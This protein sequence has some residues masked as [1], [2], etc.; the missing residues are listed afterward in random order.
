M[1]SCEHAARTLSHINAPL[2]AGRGVPVCNQIVC[3]LQR[4]DAWA[5]RR[6]ACLDFSRLQPYPELVKVLH[7]LKLVSH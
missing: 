2:N 7:D 6:V 1:T 4:N 5:A 3:H